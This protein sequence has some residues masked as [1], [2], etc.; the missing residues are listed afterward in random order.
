MNATAYIEVERPQG[1][2]GGPFAECDDPDYIEVEIEGSGG[3]WVDNNYGADADGNRGIRLEGYDLDAIS[4]SI[5]AIV[6]PRNPF[7]RFWNFLRRVEYKPQTIYLNDSDF[8][9]DEIEAAEEAIHARLCEADYEGPDPDDY[10]DRMR[11]EQMEDNYH[12]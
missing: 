7:I 12:A 6:K 5:E 10:Y 3:I 8:S 11:D 2:T 9:S 1:W 4:F